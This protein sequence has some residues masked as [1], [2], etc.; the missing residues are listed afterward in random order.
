MSSDPQSPPDPNPNPNP[1]SNP[2]PQSSNTAP[3]AA[4][5]AG[6]ADAADA[7]AESEVAVG[8]PALQA[9]QTTLSRRWL[10]RVA[11]I[12]IIGWGLFGWGLYDAMVLYPNRGKDAAS[13]L[14]Y[15]YLR[16]VDK[17]RAITAGVDDPAAEFARIATKKRDNTMSPVESARYNWLESLTRIHQLNPDQTKI[18]DA[19]AALKELDEQWGRAN[20]KVPQPLDWYDIPSQWAIAACGLVIGLWRLITFLAVAAKKY[21]WD[22]A[23]STITLPGGATLTEA[24]IIDYDKRKWDK[25]IITLDMRDGHATG[26]KELTLD[27]YPYN[28]L[29]PWVLELE[30]RGTGSVS[31]PPKD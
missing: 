2:T 16:E 19:R 3:D 28:E 18:P 1:N 9:T 12:L 29:E 15:Q 11:V 21:K 7:A 8:D 22:P 5:S 20:V 24:D 13:Y 23:S 30:R 10:V 17:A 6:V 4:D 31:E 27:L 25:F 14:K 26:K